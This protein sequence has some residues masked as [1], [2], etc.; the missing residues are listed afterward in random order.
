M[1]NEF[2]EEKL[3]SVK[4]KLRTMIRVY[5]NGKY[6]VSLMILGFGTLEVNSREELLGRIREIAELT[7]TSYMPETETIKN[8]GGSEDK[9]YKIKLI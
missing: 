1:V 3:E 6:P 2:K 8:E 4:N 5:N 7:Q 9:S